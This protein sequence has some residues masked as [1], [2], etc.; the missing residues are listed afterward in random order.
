MSFKS[1]SDEMTRYAVAILMSLISA[2]ASAAEPPK[3]TE[4]QDLSYYLDG[5]GQK[6]PIKSVAD[7]E[8]RRA[9]W[10]CRVTPGSI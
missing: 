7:W 3:Y 1:R 4:H 8:K 5:Q 6:H 2:S 10:C 9:R